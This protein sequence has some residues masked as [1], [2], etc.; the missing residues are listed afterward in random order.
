[1]GR[2]LWAD[3]QVFGS[4]GLWVFRSLGFQVLRSGCEILEASF[5]PGQALVDVLSCPAEGE[6]PLLS[7]GWWAQVL[8]NFWNYIQR[9]STLGSSEPLSLCWQTQVFFFDVAFSIVSSSCWSSEVVGASRNP[10]E[11]TSW[12]SGLHNRQS[13]QPVGGFRS[14]GVGQKQL[15]GSEALNTFLKLNAKS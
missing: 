3:R 9:F 8:S 15:I 11:Q 14:P 10:Q 12:S 6:F 13:M 5:S 7:S 1:M 2:F 4:L